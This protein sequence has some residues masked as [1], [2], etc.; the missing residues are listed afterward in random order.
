VYFGTL[1]ALNQMT[2]KMNLMIVICGKKTH[3]ICISIESWKRKK[4]VFEWWKGMVRE[5]VQWRL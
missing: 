5:Y 3:K 4:S 2:T 1:Y